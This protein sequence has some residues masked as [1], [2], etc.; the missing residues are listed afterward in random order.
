M[1]PI[2]KAVIDI[3]FAGIQGLTT[4]DFPGYLS[5]VIFTRGCSWNCR[6]CH[7]HE[8]R[9]N[10][11]ESLISWKSI[12]SFLKS[13]LGY[14]EG[15]VISGGEPTVHP[16]LPDL[17]SYIRELGF[18]TAIHTNGFSTSMLQKLI[19]KRLVDYMALD[20]KGPP[21]VYDR[22]TRSRDTCLPVSK[23]INAIISS[24]IEYEFRTTYHPM[25][26]SEEEL[27]ETM[28]TLSGIGC[29]RYYLQKFRKEGVDDPEISNFELSVLPASAVTLGEKLFP[30]FGTR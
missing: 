15:I 27:L 30:E 16:S 13:R 18:K 6:Y 19:K 3:P 22:I 10:I 2:E 1:L 24:G 14:I 5:A 8:L 26:L 21:R 7:N 20:V 12:E 4:I 11:K 17:L 28:Q 25:I 23:S 29:R 9:Y